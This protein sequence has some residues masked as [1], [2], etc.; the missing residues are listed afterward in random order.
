MSK[1]TTAIMSAFIMG[2]I[3]Q[4]I[5]AV[6]AK[7][8]FMSKPILFCIAA[9]FLVV[10]AVVSGIVLESDNGKTKHEKAKSYKDYA[11]SKSTE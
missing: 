8:S 4:L 7:V 6:L 3:V 11:E 1:R 10:I 2:Q 9:G 5:L